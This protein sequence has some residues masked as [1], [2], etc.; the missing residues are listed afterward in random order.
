MIMIF[1]MMVWIIIWIAYH[2]KARKLVMTGW[3]RWTLWSA[4]LAII[5]STYTT[6]WDFEHLELAIPQFRFRIP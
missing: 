6:K 2:F 4:D 5:S 1:M 3:L